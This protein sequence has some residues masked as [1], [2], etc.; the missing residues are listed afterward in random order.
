MRNGGYFVG[1]G[2][3]LISAALCMGLLLSGCGST[4][5]VETEGAILVDTAQVGR[6]TLVLS[7]QFVGMVSP[8]ESVYIIP[9]AQGTVTETFFEVGDEVKAGDVL[10]KIDDSGA[11]LQLEQ[12]QLSYSNVQQQADSALTTQQE[13]T[14]LQLESNY[15]SA[16]QAY[17]NAQ[18]N[19]FKL[20]DAYED[21]DDAV[22]KVQKQINKLKGMDDPVSVATR[23]QLKLTLNGNPAEEKVGL[24]S[25]RDQAK[26]AFDSITVQYEAAQRTLETLEATKELTQGAALEDT[27]EQLNTSLQLAKVGVESAELALS[28]YQVTTPISGEVISKNVEVNGMATASSPAYIIAAEDTMSVSFQVSEAVRNTLHKDMKI[29]VERSGV[30]FDGVITEVGN[31]VNAQTGLFQIKAAVYASGSELPSGVSVKITSDTYTAANAIIIPYDAVYYE[32]AGSYVYTVKDGHAVKT[33]VTTGIFDDE[34]IEIVDG[35]TEEDIII[36]SWSPRLIDGAEV[37]AR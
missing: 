16:L 25:L 14:N 34:R 5:V 32:N 7:N 23:E 36:T 3:C 8:E 18:L 20:K 1:K 26:D 12:A 11:R 6:D 15:A 10:F 29:V 33:Y 21:A 37:D 31:A 28:Y 24:K 19:Y 9:M 22:E 17:Q 13:S 2:K 4:E 35:I 27:K 30:E